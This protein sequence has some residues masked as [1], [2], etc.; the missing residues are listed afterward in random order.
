MVISIVLLQVFG[1]DIGS[2][3]HTRRDLLG[4]SHHGKEV[5]NLKDHTSIHP[6]IHPNRSFTLSIHSSTQFI[7]P[8]YTTIHQP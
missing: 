8:S 2:D 1:T 5:F 3:P 6:F 7:H 4:V